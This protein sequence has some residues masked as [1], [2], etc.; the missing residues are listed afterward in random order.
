MDKVVSFFGSRYEV[1][2]LYER[3]VEQTL[4]PNPVLAA[5]LPGLARKVQQR[6]RQLILMA[7]RKKRVL[8]KLLAVRAFQ[9]VAESVLFRRLGLPES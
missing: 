8:T 4:F 2:L 6:E 1:M 9:S 7:P 5:E 3:I